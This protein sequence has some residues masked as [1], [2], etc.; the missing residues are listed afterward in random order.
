[1]VNFASLKYG[2]GLCQN[3]QFPSSQGVRKEIKL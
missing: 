3:L 2:Y 1:M